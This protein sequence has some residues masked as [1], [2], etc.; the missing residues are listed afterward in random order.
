V[1]NVGSGKETLSI[2]GHSGDVNALCVI[3]TT[4]FS[5]ADAM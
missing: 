4:L 3:G 1:V 2:E 5:G